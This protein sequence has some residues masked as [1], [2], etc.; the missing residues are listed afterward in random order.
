M[1]ALRRGEAVEN[2]KPD[3]RCDMSLSEPGGANRAWVCED[4][5]E[6]VPTDPDCG[7]LRF[8]SVNRVDYKWQFYNQETGP[9]NRCHPPRK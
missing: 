4:A 1:A 2:L 8:E 3:L 9:R 7:N 6:Q 5:C